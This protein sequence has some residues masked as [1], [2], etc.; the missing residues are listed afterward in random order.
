MN[1]RHCILINYQTKGL[2]S[3]MFCTYPNMIVHPPDTNRPD[4]SMNFAPIWTI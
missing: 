4:T 2:Q 3:P 1:T